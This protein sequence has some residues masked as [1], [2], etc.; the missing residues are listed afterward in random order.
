MLFYVMICWRVASYA[1]GKTPTQLNYLWMQ[2]TLLLVRG[3]IS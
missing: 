2:D 3:V 1:D